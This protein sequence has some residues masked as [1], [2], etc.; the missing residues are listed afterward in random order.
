MK[1]V[2]TGA[3]GTIQEAEEKNEVEKG[4]D[5]HVISARNAHDMELFKD[6]FEHP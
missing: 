6:K 2:R 4:L 3:D 5:I 1:F